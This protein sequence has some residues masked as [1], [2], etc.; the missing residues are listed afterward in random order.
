[1]EQVNIEGKRSGEGFVAHKDQL[2]NALSRAQGERVTL[3]DSD[4][5]LTSRL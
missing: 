1:L 3:F 5:M 4:S 2:V